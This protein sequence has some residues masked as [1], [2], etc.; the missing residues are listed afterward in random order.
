MKTQP[1]YQYDVCFSF[2]SEQVAY[3]EEV[4]QNL[5][6]L[7]IRVFF[8]RDADIEMELWGSN[9]LEKFDSIYKATS[10]YCVM[11]ISK[12]YAEKAWT[13]FERRSALERAFQKDEVYIL[14]VRFDQTDLPGIHSATKYINAK[15]KTP[16]EL[17][18]LIVRKIGNENTSTKCCVE[19]EAQQLAAEL[20]K[21]FSENGYQYIVRTDL[22]GRVLIY[23]TE[24]DEKEMIYAAILEFEPNAVDQLT[25]FNFG[26]FPPTDITTHWSRNQFVQ[27]LNDTLRDSS[28]NGK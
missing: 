12:E 22:H 2:A 8:D 28:N 5:T 19:D 21:V 27:K 17:A 7:G 11:F 25:L 20:C 18:D 13:R 16:K 24:A 14:P 10:R 23:R 6:S 26:I 4:Y 15:K 3:V 9:L 1:D